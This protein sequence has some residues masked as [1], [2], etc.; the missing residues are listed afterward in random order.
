MHWNRVVKLNAH[1]KKSQFY[2]NK[3]KKVEN[4]LEKALQQKKRKF[5]HSKYVNRNLLDRNYAEK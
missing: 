3:N 2:F 5:V 1:Q 4:P